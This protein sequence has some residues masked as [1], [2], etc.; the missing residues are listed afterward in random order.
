MDTKDRIWKALEDARWDWRTVDGVSKE[1]GLPE[2]EV[3]RILESSPDEIIRSR[4]PDERGRALYTTR[5]HYRRR[6]GFLER[7]R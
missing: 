7:L 5:Q 6:Q 4:I 1:I 3:L 2:E